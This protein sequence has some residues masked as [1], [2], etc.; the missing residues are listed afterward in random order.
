GITMSI[1]I[2]TI[3]DV[4][5]NRFGVAPE[6]CA[7]APGRVNI[8]GEHTDYNHGFVLPMAI[9]HET[10]IVGAPRR[11]NTLRLFAR[12]LD[13]AASVS[14]DSRVRNAA[15]PWTDYIMGVADQL[16]GLDKPV[17]GADMAIMGDVPVGC[18]LSSSAALEM[19]ALVFFEQAG[20]FKIDDAEAARLGQRVENEFLGLS[21]GIMDQFISR[22]GKKG[23]ALFLDCRSYEYQLTPVDFP[24]ALFVIA[25][26]ACPRGL[27]ASKYNE[28]VAECR[29]AVA[30][31]RQYFNASGAYLRDYTMNDLLAAQETLDGVAF[32]RAR[33]VIT[34]NDRTLAACDA[35][36][37]G[38]ATK[39]G[40]LMNESDISLRA[41]YE[42][43]S[44][45]L[46]ILTDAARSHADCFG[47]RMTGAGFGGC[48]L[49][50]VRRDA[51]TGFCDF[52]LERYRAK[53]GKQGEVFVS[54]PA[55][56][57]GPVFL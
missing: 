46:D 53:A 3:C 43:T 12:N 7:R 2:K 11:D 48:T 45:E 19:A 13:R 18:G 29:R 47:A 15:E 38:D 22:C 54:S 21:T 14:L 6:I 39:L 20:G 31:L 42:V 57:A 26:T 41:D 28:R 30:S 52:L 4:Y 33:H 25:N 36:R 50:L 55:D 34:E 8:I 23:H 27:T 32:R 37:R 10:V 40:A 35:M 51:V 9:E 44:R 24:D 5:E 56:G 1:D 49:N 17:R 16:I